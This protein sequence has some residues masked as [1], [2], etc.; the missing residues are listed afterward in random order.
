MRDKLA[1]VPLSL[2]L[3]VARVGIGSVFLK[4][5]LLKYQSWQITLLLFRDEYKVPLIDP[6][7][8]AKMATFNELTFST[9]LLLGVAT[10]LA[11]LPFFGMILVI[12]TFVYPDAWTDHLLWASGLLLLLTRGGGQLSLDYMIGRWF[13]RRSNALA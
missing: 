1:A 7:L 13:T 4:A 8:L 11:T 2:I 6:T 9:L 12:Q 3:L 5:G 10:R